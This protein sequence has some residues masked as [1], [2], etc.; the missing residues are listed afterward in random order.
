V[1]LSA[2][3]AIEEATASVD[4]T[5]HGSIARALTQVEVSMVE[6]VMH[7][8]SG[9]TGELVGVGLGASPGRA[10]GV[11]VRS[12]DDALAA[13]ERGD[14][15]VFVSIETAPVDEPALRVAAAVLTARGGLAS[16]AAVLARDLGIPAVC[17][18]A[19]VATLV[20]GESILVDGGN[21]EV[22]V[23]E[24]GPVDAGLIDDV[25]APD[26]LP[27][28]LATL[29][30]WADEVS[31]TRL[32]VRANVD[33]AP[34]ARRARR[35]GA[36]G[37][38]LCRIEHVFLGTR[39]ATLRQAARG[40]GDARAE[41]GRLLR[42]ELVDLFAEMDGLPV[43]VR[44]LDAPVHEFGE[45]T[46]HNP[47]LGLRGVRAAI[48]DE[49]L[50]RAQLQA[51]ADA[52]ATRRAAGGQPLVEVLVPLVSLPAELELVGGWVREVTGLPVGVMIETPRAALAADRLAPLVESFSF[53]TNDLTQLT[54]GWSRD[55]LDGQLL[56]TYRDRGIVDVSPFETLDTGAVVRLMALAVET[57]RAA[58]PDLRVGLCGEQ[59]AERRSIE[60]ALQLG[61]DH[62][63]CAPGRVPGARL[64]AA[65]A[66]LATH[67]TAGGR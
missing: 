44:M 20:D 11:V 28:A 57:G 35:F 65:Q 33:L 16:H 62:V 26:E 48:V 22:R 8:S 36:K 55:D 5:D 58:N 7:A 12:V 56:P 4:P 19:A 45:G 66:V 38:G 34:S 40:D 9:A 52:V 27:A 6:E 3:D 60:V 14:A 29:L 63:S 21:G 17:G 47:M 37:V 49:P 54:Y 30:G 50:A 59:A 61:L 64:A 39:V 53:G 13:Y 25:P 15:V 1:T 31:A 2:A 10:V 41:V 51:I 23:V 42:D 43:V 32:E 67:A 24:G 46:E 18:F